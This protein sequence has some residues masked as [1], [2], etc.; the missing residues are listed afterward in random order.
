[1]E[2]I[3]GANDSN[4]NTASAPVGGIGKKGLSGGII[5]AIIL[6][7]LLLV[8]LFAT[9]LLRRR[10]LSR[11]SERFGAWWTNRRRNSRTY[12]DDPPYGN[13]KQPPSNWNRDDFAIS[14][15]DRSA[16]P[17]DLSNI[18]PMAPPMAE[19]R[20]LRNGS[21]AHLVVPTS[22]E[23]LSVGSNDS[24]VIH[25]PTAVTHRTSGTESFKFPK[26][27]SHSELGA[28]GSIHSR[29]GSSGSNSGAA[30]VTAACGHTP[31]NQSQ[32]SLLGSRPLVPS[33][34]SRQASA[35]GIPN[36][37]ADT[38]GSESLHNPFANTSMSSTGP[39]PLAVGDLTRIEK[40]RRPFLPTMTDE[41]G[42]EVDD[43]VKILQI[44]DDGWALVEKAQGTPQQGLIPLACLRD[45]GQAL[46]S[47]LS[48]RRV[49]SIHVSEHITQ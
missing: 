25:H 48:T 19:V 32:P 28:A 35:E 20:R 34:L 36:P 26:P 9:A 6:L 3:P 40:I 12:G 4:D 27:P 18:V 8:L 38:D 37:F 14:T 49:Q 2:T 43:E 31:F 15:M 16:S 21:D 13:E 11:K 5:A 17:L 30:S 42:V 45:L 29:F 22:N 44:F 47:L 10:W 23:R 33:S 39:L 24:F 46:T 1:L 7:V 41:L